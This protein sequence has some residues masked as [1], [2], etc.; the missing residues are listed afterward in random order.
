MQLKFHE[1]SLQRNHRGLKAMRRLFGFFA[2]LTFLSVFTFIHQLVL[3]GMLYGL[4]CGYAYLIID[5]L[6]KIF[7]SEEIARNE[8]LLNPLSLSS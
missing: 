3:I 5:S 7:E 8:I 6:Y 1:I 4:I 2:V